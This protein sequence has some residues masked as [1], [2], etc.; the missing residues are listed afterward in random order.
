[1]ICASLRAKSMLAAQ[2]NRNIFFTVFPFKF[3]D[4]ASIAK[5]ILK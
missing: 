5:E 2:R 3:F 4:F 1:M